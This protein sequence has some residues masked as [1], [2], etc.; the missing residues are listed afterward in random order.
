M[1]KRTKEEQNDLK[2]KI[3]SVVES[4]TRRT[5]CLNIAGASLAQ[6]AREVACDKSSAQYYLAQ[7]QKD[8]LVIFNGQYFE[9]AK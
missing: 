9:V 8:G 2:Q 3:L 1:N 5:A 7:L 4:V 6:I